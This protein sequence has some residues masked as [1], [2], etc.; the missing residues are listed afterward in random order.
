MGVALGTLTGGRLVGIGA[1]E[2]ERKRLYRELRY[3]SLL[4]IFL[5]VAIAGVVLLWALSK[6]D[7]LLDQVNMELLSP[8]VI[9]VL[10]VDLYFKKV[11]T[12]VAGTEFVLYAFVSTELWAAS[13]PADIRATHVDVL[14][15]FN[16]LEGILPDKVSPAEPTAEPTHTAPEI[17]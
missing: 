15:E 3:I 14:S 4:Q 17:V 11:S 13:M 1:G 16:R 5:V 12:T 8:K 7:G 2:E 9:A 6:H 10:L